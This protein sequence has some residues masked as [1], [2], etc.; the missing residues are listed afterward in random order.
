MS[1]FWSI[2][3]A[4]WAGS[5][6][7]PPRPTSPLF[8]SSLVG[9]PTPPLLESSYTSILRDI[10][11]CNSILC[12][13]VCLVIYETAYLPPLLQLADRYHE[14]S[15]FVD[16]QTSDLPCQPF[17]FFLS[18]EICQGRPPTSPLSSSSLIG[19]MKTNRKTNSSIFRPQIYPAS[20]SN[21]LR[22][23]RCAVCP[24]MF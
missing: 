16:F 7:H 24:D 14:P 1:I 4:A 9:N 11:S 12:V 23:F 10:S 5:S 2:G 20:H 21:Y 15:Q 3:L 19:T 18:F 8:S 6:L 17:K 22:V 13:F